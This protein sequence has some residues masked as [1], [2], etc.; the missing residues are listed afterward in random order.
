MRILGLF[1]KTILLT[2]THWKVASFNRYA[3]SGDEDF[4]RDDTLTLIKPAPIPSSDIR[5][6]SEP[7][8]LKGSIELSNDDSEEEKTA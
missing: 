4:D 3:Y 8:P 2:G 5:I 1:M 6:P 7:R